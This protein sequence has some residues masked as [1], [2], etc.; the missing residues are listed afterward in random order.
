MDN[1]ILGP[2]FKIIT[3]ERRIQLARDEHVHN[4]ESTAGTVSRALI[5]N[6]Q[7]SGGEIYTSGKK[8]R[9]IAPLVLMLFAP[10]GKATEPEFF[11][12]ACA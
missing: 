4:L 5:R 9:F 6:K 1:C 10:W 12:A 8:V 7:G 11:L 2:L 3:A